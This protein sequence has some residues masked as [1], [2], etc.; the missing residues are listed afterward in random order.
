MQGGAGKKMS[1]QQRRKM[2]KDAREQERLDSIRAEVER[3]MAENPTGNQGAVEEAGLKQLCNEL[4]LQIH[5]I[6]PD[7]HCLYSAIADQL[8]VRYPMEELYTYQHMRKAAASYMRQHADD[9]I[10]FISDLDESAAGVDKGAQTAAEKFA[11]YCDAMESSSAWG[12]Q[13]EILALS[14]VLHTPIHV[15]QAGMP[16]VK[17]G[18]EEVGDRTPLTISYHVKMYGL[19]EHY[20]SL[21][22]AASA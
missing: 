19:G 7:G 12:G 22:P 18:D 13:P 11:Q 1:R 2:N 10:P 14:K 3:E 5:E 15:I 20:N 4:Q 16:V 17:I 21:R 8:N 9:F 6:T